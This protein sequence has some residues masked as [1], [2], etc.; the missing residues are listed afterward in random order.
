MRKK[1]SHGA[2][3]GYVSFAVCGV[4]QLR[5]VQLH[6]LAAA[7][8]A[9]ALSEARLQELSEYIEPQN[10]QKDKKKNLSPNL[11][12]LGKRG[13]Q[14][15]RMAQEG[16]PSPSNP[17]KPKKKPAAAAKSVPSKKPAA[18]RPKAT[19]REPVASEPVSGAPAAREPVD[20]KPAHRKRQGAGARGP[21]R[22]TKYTKTAE[23]EICFY[24]SSKAPNHLIPKYSF[25]KLTKDCLNKVQAEVG[26][27]EPLRFSPEAPAAVQTGCEAFLSGLFSDIQN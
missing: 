14:Q 2:F 9:D 7:L 8:D 23:K 12:F 18:R 15:L 20:A 24:R 17:V 25:A 16:K 22:G 13:R 4:S 3:E 19:A 1:I 10:S 6:P 27:E 5:P 26:A 11:G 21:L